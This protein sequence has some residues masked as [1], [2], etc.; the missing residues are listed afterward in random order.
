MDENMK[1]K[2]DPP[3]IID[4]SCLYSK[5]SKSKKSG[6]PKADQQDATREKLQNENRELREK[7]KS[8]K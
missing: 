7:L 4:D 1:P 5:D 6:E 3:L 2:D 8:L